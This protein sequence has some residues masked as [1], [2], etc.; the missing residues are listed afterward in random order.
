MPIVAA[1]GVGM[2]VISAEH[3]FS[4]FLSSPWTTAKFVETEE[5]KTQIRRLYVMAIVCSLVTA[6]VLSHILKQSW[7]LVAA[8]ILCVVYVIVYERAL[9][10]KI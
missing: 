9:R 4:T 7:P 3:F 2:S 6:A 8:G 10:G 5:D 1:A